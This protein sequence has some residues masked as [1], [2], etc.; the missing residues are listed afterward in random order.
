MDRIA[1]LSDIPFGLADNRHIQSVRNTYIRSFEKLLDFKT[2]STISDDVV[3][4]ELL[5]KILKDHNGVVQSMAVGVLERKMEVALSKESTQILNLYLNRFFMA[6]IGIRFLIDH[7]I[8]SNNTHFGISGII[9]SECEPASVAR[10]AADDCIMLCERQYGVSP[11]IKI[12]T[13]HPISFTYVPSH[14]HYILSEL[15]KNALRA[16][17]VHHG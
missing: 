14:L 1:E 15:F 2:P 5:K 13:P 4:T 3:Y 17:I 11:E 16:T 9:H 8:A 12:V 6:R 10:Q 7:H